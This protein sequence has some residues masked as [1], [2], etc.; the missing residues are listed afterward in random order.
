MKLLQPHSILELNEDK[1]QLEPFEGDVKDLTARR[2]YKLFQIYSSWNDLIMSLSKIDKMEDD[3][4]KCVIYGIIDRIG[5]ILSSTN[6][7]EELKDEC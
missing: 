2:N 7:D 5:R 4:L 1:I 3:E 6:I